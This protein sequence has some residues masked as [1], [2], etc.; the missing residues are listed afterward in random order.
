MPRCWIPPPC[1]PLIRRLYR[2]ETHF[3]VKKKKPAVG[4]EDVSS[5]IEK[6][7]LGKKRK[8]GE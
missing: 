2:K 3:R 5:F 1:T 6:K 8:T 7:G 4:G